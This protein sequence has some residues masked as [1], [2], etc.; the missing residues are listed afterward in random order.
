MRGRIIAAACAA[1]ALADGAA[2]AQTM[3][4]RV[5]QALPDA[6]TA[7]PARAVFALRLAR[8]LAGAPQALCDVWGLRSSVPVEQL[9]GAK[10]DEAL[11][12][13]GVPEAELGAAT[14]KP[15]IALRCQ[16]ALP[17]GA[18]VSLRWLRPERAQANDESAGVGQPNWEGTHFHYKVQSD[19]P[20]ALTC[21]RVN[22]GA[23]CNPLDKVVLQFNNPVNAGDL[24]RVRLKAPNGKLVAPLQAEQVAAQVWA[25]AI[26]FRG[27]AANQRYTIAWP[28][29][30]GDD[31]GNDVLARARKL[32]PLT[33]RMG[34]YPPL[35]KFGA[36]FGIA[37]KN[38]GGVVPLTVRAVEGGSAPARLRTLRLTEEADIIQAYQ[39]LVQVTSHDDSMA[40]RPGWGEEM[41]E[42]EPPPLPAAA[43]SGSKFR[44]AFPFPK[45]KNQPVDTR[46][47]AWLQRLP[48]A[49]TQ[50][51][52]RQLE[53]REFEVLGVP[54]KEPGLHLMEVESRALGRGLLAT[55][56]PMFVRA[57]A[58]V[59][60]LGV[61][62]HL[63]HRSA[64]IW[65]TRLSD[66]KPVPQ[67]QVALFDCKARQVAAGRANAQ[68]WVTLERKA[69][70][71]EWQCP[72]YAFAR[73]GGDLGFVQSQW[74]RGIEGWR[75][76]A[77]NNFYAPPTDRV[78]HAV[79]ARNLLRPGETM[80]ARLFWRHI[81]RSGA[82]E[83]P[84]PAVLPR[85]IDIVHVGSGERRSVAVA[86]DARGNADL[87]WKLPAGAKRG[88]YL[89]AFGGP[90]G[91]QG[92][93]FRVEDFRLP[94]LKAEV[95]SPAH[96]QVLA[97]ASKGAPARIEASLRLAYLS[98]GAAA[99]ESVHVYQ[100]LVPLTPRF[101][102]FPDFWF[103]NTRYRWEEASDDEMLASE[104]D[105]STPVGEDKASRL[106][107][108]GT[109][110]VTARFE[111]PLLAPRT[112]VTE[113]EYR[114]PNGETYRAQGR[115]PVWPAAIVLGVKA[116]HWSDKP[117]RE[118]EFVAVDP[119][120]KPVAGTEVAVE[121][122]FDGY[123]S[124]R[125]KVV[126]GYYSYHSERRE[127]QPAP[128]CKGRT[129]ARGRY[130]CRF[131]PDL[132]EVDGG[133]FRVQATGQD[134]QGRAVKVA[135]G[136]WVYSGGEVWFTQSDH[137]RIDVLADKPRYKP[138]DTA[139]LQVRS[140]FREATA[141]V[142]VM[143]D[144]TVV[145]TLVLPLTGSQPTLKLPIKAAYA[146]NV[147]FNVLAVRGRVAEPAPTALV[148]LA[149]PAYKLGIVGVEVGSDEQLLK[150]AVRTDRPQ[151]QSRETARVQIKV[152]AQ[153]G[154][155]PAQREATVFVI[156]E[157][158]LE[159]MPNGTWD[160]FRAMTAKRGY[161]FETSS[162]SMQVIGKRHYGR[163]ALPPGGGGGK[164]AARE[165]FDTLLVW[166]GSVP[167]DEN[168]NAQVDVPVNDSLTR[169]R[170]VAVAN[171]GADR[172][173]TGET[174][175]VATKDLQLLSGLPATVREGERFTAGFTVR[176]TTKMPMR[177]S[178]EA[179]LNDKSLP[180]QNVS[181]APGEAKGV[182][183]PVD[184]PAQPGA[185]RWRVDAKAAMPDGARS[186][187]L[188]VQ[189]AVHPALA[190][191]RFT[192]AA[193][194][195]QSG[196]QPAPMAIRPPAGTVAGRGELRVGLSPAL[197]AD[198]S[199]V[200]D[201][202]RGYPFFCL[203]QRTSKAVA[204]KDKALWAIITD[205][206]D[207][208]VTP[209][210][211]VTYYPGAGD[212][213]YDVLT[214]FVLS[215]SHEA[216]WK[217]PAE[218]ERR[219]LDGL[220]QFVRGK[221]ELNLPYYDDDAY[222]LT[223]RKLLALEALARHR[224]V[225][226]ALG[227]SLKLDPAKDLPQLSHRALT[228]WL[229]VLNRVSWPN[230]AAATTA[231]LA[232]LDRRL[233]VDTRG[234]L[235]LRERAAERR[236][237][238][239]T[240]EPTSQV[241]LALLA[242]DLPALSQRASLLALAA[243]NLQ[244][245]GATWWDTQAN[246]WGSLMLDKRALRAK[247]AISGTTTM[248]VGGVTQV[249]DWARQPE[250]ETYVFPASAYATRSPA[251]A[252]S[253]NGNG[254]PVATASG[255]AWAELNQPHQQQAKV[256]RTIRAI[257]QATPGR[258]T[259]GDIAEVELHFEVAGNSGWFVLSDPIPTGATLLG[260]GL[261][262]QAVVPAGGDKGGRGW[263][264]RDGTWEAMPM[265]VERTFTHMR[266]YYEYLWHDKLRF[267]YQMRINNAGTFKLPPTQ[268]EAMYDPGI[269]AY[270][271]NVPLEVK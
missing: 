251:L 226:A 45:A 257:Q 192:V 197:A 165:L 260:S 50:A 93:E 70:P 144:G 254:K 24:A 135:T 51:L 124:Y 271:P 190:P 152:A 148:D 246:V 170:V 185:M 188:A 72:L 173:G 204:L 203:E 139:T 244:G 270:Q 223:E 122:G 123:I 39:E 215:A 30:V 194:E 158:L 228:Q 12:A 54:L 88:A 84:A 179:S 86:W 138:G 57:G 200:R 175:F 67:A 236:W 113:M 8:P 20:V 7:V 56:R 263:R 108:N 6:N 1:L 61:H 59:T 85:A 21:S 174:S 205:N 220:E 168:G 163:K 103:G 211:L 48:D 146:P 52:P 116:Q 243:V 10:R 96:A 193:V 180:R 184:V 269:F 264:H 126:G 155:L 37:E 76:D 216:G 268:L 196:S 99:N 32:Q 253:H 41:D 262:G 11:R 109:L 266:A 26:E 132:S 225:D 137:D 156:D 33:V 249:H 15:W 149:R 112:L 73:E 198:A 130:T 66:G 2:R 129:D 147:F 143:R 53:G 167:L 245:Q 19:W 234:G 125:R 16:A 38:A 217:L 3:Q 31:R 106:D 29:R 142:S 95:V 35:V 250:G 164:S 68:G 240:S 69:Q 221:V 43:A 145:D 107:A 214:S 150:V 191:V 171:A 74:Q 46:G 131:T 160:L 94:V 207:S 153:S 115:T 128:L 227:E 261:K 172:F 105:N 40:R 239:M 237:Y 141:W 183:W 97:P 71:N 256:A 75:F 210:G 22:A 101:E 202:M 209:S 100:R 201:Y 77:I 18:S 233:V 34:D 42:G 265:Y 181:L 120:G 127:F 133:E 5:L 154:A 195:L 4:P 121:G 23:G 49:H 44:Y 27:L 255:T 238:L 81:G 136:M 140:P 231:A 259:A 63:S 28:E 87:G 248:T 208:Y 176:N 25:H 159:L 17:D 98:G 213:G 212:G 65:V 235:R 199:G 219:M 166:R 229:D 62:L 230:K 60:D 118:V 241:R 55:G 89:I 104:P 78:A 64:S 110:K 189:Q 252:L 90:G 267:T 161:G 186:D 218:A 111:K 92:V 79:L 247:G 222:N 169:F 36:V 178:V 114:D 119:Q 58:L 258:W 224:K 157:A 162:A 80:N 182:A 206:I 14:G 102:A 177:A 151:Y 232:E 187:A 242:L 91:G 82:L 9:Q 47:I 13:L 117:Q 134:A 83:A